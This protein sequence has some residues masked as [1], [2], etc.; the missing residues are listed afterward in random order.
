MEEAEEYKVPKAV[1][2]KSSI[3]EE[4]LPVLLKAI[5]VTKNPAIKEAINAKRFT[6]DINN[7]IFVRKELLRFFNAFARVTE[8]IT[9]PNVAP[10]EIPIIPGSAKG[11]LKNN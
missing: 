11:F 7:V 4:F 3:I 10:E 8:A 6:G 9:A 2:H 5:K 1:P